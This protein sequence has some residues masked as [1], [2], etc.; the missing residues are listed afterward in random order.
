MNHGLS[1]MSNTNVAAHARVCSEW[2]CHGHLCHG[3]YGG[4]VQVCDS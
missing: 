4:M 3:R 2:L 1:S